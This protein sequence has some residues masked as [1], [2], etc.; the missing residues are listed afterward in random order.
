M[1]YTPSAQRLDPFL[2]NH[3]AGNRVHKNLT[4]W[5]TR[6]NVYPSHVNILR[7]VEKLH[8]PKTQPIFSEASQTKWRKDLI[9]QPEFPVALCNG[10]YRLQVADQRLLGGESYFTKILGCAITTVILLWLRVL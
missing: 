4:W 5:E 1:L 3:P 8:H 2:T 9:F 7:S 6:Y 10:K